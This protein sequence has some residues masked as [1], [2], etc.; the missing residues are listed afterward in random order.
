MVNA[1]TGGTSVGAD[2][3]YDVHWQNPMERLQLRNVDDQFVG[4]FVRTEA[5]MTWSGRNDDGFAFQSDPANTAT[6]IF[7]EVGH[8]RNGT[9]FS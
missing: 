9:F 2:V 5:T 7:A 6:T 3:T 8:E 1:L 4:Q